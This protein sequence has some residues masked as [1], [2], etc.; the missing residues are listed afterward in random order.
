MTIAPTYS[1]RAWLRRCLLCVSGA[2]LLSL[3]L[4]VAATAAPTV[5]DGY[6]ISLFA[7]APSGDSSPDDICW[8]DGHLF[9]GYQNGVGP[10]GEPNSGGGTTSAVVEYDGD[11]SVANQWSI[12]GKVDGLGADPH[13]QR[14]IA[15]VN[16]DSNSSLVTIAPWAWPSAQL[17]DY[18]YS[19]SPSP[20]S[21]V[22]R[23]HKGTA[24]GVN[25]FKRESVEPQSRPLCIPSSPWAT[26]GRSMS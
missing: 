12:T 26:T 1:S 6:T 11:G 8:L 7:S 15:T 24:H 18:Q 21:G 22:G 19:P 5:P 23:S 2:L 20:A 16:E 4:A 3:S 17:T 9:V 14:V 13:G 10:N 25:M